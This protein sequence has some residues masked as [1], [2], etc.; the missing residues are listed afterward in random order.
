MVSSVGQQQDQVVDLA[1]AALQPELALQRLS[2]ADARLSLDPDADVGEPQERIPRSLVTGDREGD[3]GAPAGPPSE[4]RPEP[5]EQGQMRA[6]AKRVTT[7]I[8]AHAEVET[9]HLRG[10]VQVE[11]RQ[12]RRFAA[13]EPTPGG[14]GA[15]DRRG[16]SDLAETSVQPCPTH[17]S[18]HL[19]QSCQRG[20]P[21]L[22]VASLLSCHARIFAS[23]TYRRLRPGLT[24]TS[25][26]GGHR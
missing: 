1:V 19:R 8:R 24:G 22:V 18:A 2:I 14:G 23:S 7:G 11:E 10:T 9:H 26:D 5:F 13:L 20:P 4:S 17:L 15:T 16:R 21:C 12:V 25:V 6:V 3:L